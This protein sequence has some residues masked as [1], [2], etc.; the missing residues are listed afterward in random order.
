MHRLQQDAVDVVAPVDQHGRIQ[1]RQRAA[2]HHG[3]RDRHVV[4]PRFTETDGPAGVEFRG[5]D[6]QPGVEVAEVVG[7]SVDPVDLLEVVQHGFVVEQPDGQGPG[8]SQQRDDEAAVR[9]VAEVAPY[10]L[11]QQ[12]GRRQPSPQHLPDGRREE[13]RGDERVFARLV[14]DDGAHVLRG[15]DAVGEIRAD[16]GARAHPD[17]DAE[18][19]EVEAVQGLVERPQHADLVDGAFWPAPGEREADAVRPVRRCRSQHAFPTGDHDAAGRCPPP[20]GSPRV[21]RHS[22]AGSR[23]PPKG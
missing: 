17:V 16:E 9:R 7:P 20:V 11:Q 5:D 14:L 19:V 22:A 18:V 2:G 21:T 13:V 23:G 10:G 8:H 4:A 12:G 6:V 15:G 1:P 3:Q